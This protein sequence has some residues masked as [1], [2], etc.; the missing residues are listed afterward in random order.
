MKAAYIVLAGLCAVTLRADLETSVTV[1]F[2]VPQEVVSQCGILEG[3]DADDAKYTPLISG[4]E[5]ARNFSSY[6]SRVQKMLDLGCTVMVRLDDF[7]RRNGGLMPYE[8]WAL[9]E[10]FVLDQAQ[11]WGTNVVY[12][13]WNEP[14]LS[15]FWP[16]TDAQYYE[17]YRRAHTVIKNELG[18][19]AKVSG[20]SAHRWYTTYIEDFLDYCVGEGLTVEVL[21]WHEL[22]ERDDDIPSIQSHLEYAR[23]HWKDDPAYASLGI[24]QIVLGET[25]GNDRTYLPGSTL[26]Y[27]HYA[28]QGGSDGACSSCWNSDCENGSISGLLNGPNGDPRA[29]WW[30]F[31]S[32]ADGVAGRVESTTLDERVVPL[33]SRQVAGSPGTAQVLLGYFEFGS[34]PDRADVTLTLNNL[35]SV[36]GFEANGAVCI[37]VETIP[38]TGSSSLLEPVYVGEATVDLTG[39]SAAVLLPDLGLEEVAVLTLSPA[40]STFRLH[41][42]DPDPAAFSFAW[43]STTGEFFNIHRSTNLA[44]GFPPPPLDENH[45]AAAG[46]ETEYSDTRPP[47]GSAAFYRVAKTSGAIFE[48]GFE[49]GVLDPQK[50]TTETT[51]EGRVRVSDEY[52]GTGRFGVLLDDEVYGSIKSIAA[53]ITAPLDLTAIPTPTLSFQW[54]DFSDNADPEDGVFI[55]TDDGATWQQLFSF[56]DGPSEYTWKDIPLDAYAAESAVRIKFQFYDNYPIP[57]D[58]FGID[59]I[60]VAP[61]ATRISWP[62]LPAP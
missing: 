3:R 29:V 16:G 28:E 25:V 24:R 58:G 46:D 4:T 6:N 32:Y 22:N 50:W 38:D 33:G 26:G 12:D 35:D 18:S 53:L 55:S 34:T 44:E 41:V 21:Q 40:E 59:S 52:P 8:N 54:K 60:F 5:W 31:K 27:F 20:P 1:D 62:I 49:S 7:P 43:P 42:T 10:S 17:A 39:G 61:S 13:V 47:P 36:T 48:D 9:W 45:P 15:M 11:T 37:Q 14:N 2:A 30:T 19:S 23:T 56:N 51:L 57:S